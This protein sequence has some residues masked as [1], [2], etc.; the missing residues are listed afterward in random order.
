MDPTRSG[1]PWTAPLSPPT[2]PR[3]APVAAVLTKSL[4]VHFSLS[5]RLVP[6]LQ[7]AMAVAPRDLASTAVTPIVTSEPTPRL[8]DRP[9]QSVP[10]HTLAGISDFNFISARKV[11]G[12]RPHASSSDRHSRP[13]VASRLALTVPLTT[14]LPRPG[15]PCHVHQTL[16]EGWPTG[17]PCRA[18]RWC[19][20]ATSGAAAD[21]WVKEDKRAVKIMPWRRVPVRRGALVY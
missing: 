1:V 10:H 19:G 7:K 6:P 21:Q 5:I 3:R 8:V 12:C 15:E 2:L 11:Y 17:G 14:Y 20:S 13:R 16:T 4:R 18:K 9:F